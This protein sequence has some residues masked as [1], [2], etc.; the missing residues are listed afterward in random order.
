MG[1][2]RHLRPPLILISGVIRY[3]AQR[4]RAHKREV[5]CIQIGANDGKINDPL[6]HYFDQYGWK[7]LL[8]EPQVEVF[9]NQLHKTY[10]H[11]PELILENV[12][13]GPSGKT[14]PFY[15]LSCSSARWATGLA[16]F[17]RKSID[18][19]IQSGYV[20]KKADAEGIT[21]GDDLVE[22]VLVPMLG[23]TELLERHQIE[24]ADL[25]CIDTE[26]FDFEVLQQFDFSA[27]RPNLV[28]YESKNLSDRDFISSQQ[29]LRDAGYKLYWER[30]D[31]L[32]VC[33]T[34]P[35]L[36]AAKLRF[37]ANWNRIRN[38]MRQRTRR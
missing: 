16:S 22:T 20:K 31:T 11:R 34:L 27:I 14:L 37:A 24:H 1:N 29:L 38:A 10:A 6:Y 15:R 19:H 21:L 28:L 32:A 25:L 5:F 17:D 35:L 13:I 26:G 9:E 8:V 7:G 4:C 2:P 33:M 12:A 3:F 30:G 18:A 23:F 36:V